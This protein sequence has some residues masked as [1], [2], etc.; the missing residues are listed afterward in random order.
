MDSCNIQLA[1]GPSEKIK[2]GN[3]D[4]YRENSNFEDMKKWVVD[5]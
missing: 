3:K 5:G 4:G 1:L 2:A